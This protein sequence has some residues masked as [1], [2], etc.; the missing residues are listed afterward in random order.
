MWLIL[1]TDVWLECLFVFVGCFIDAFLLGHFISCG[2]S[3]MNMGENRATYLTKKTPGYSYLAH[4]LIKRK[5]FSSFCKLF[6]RYKIITVLFI[7]IS[8]EIFRGILS[9]IASSTFATCCKELRGSFYPFVHLRFSL[10]T[11]CRKSECLNICII[12]MISSD[13]CMT[14]L[15]KIFG[16]DPVRIEVRTRSNCCNSVLFNTFFK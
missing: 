4:L 16:I 13:M 6:V 14:F 8:N 9:V 5:L 2:R 3:L 1:K 10:L 11:L 12:Y 15:T 7:M